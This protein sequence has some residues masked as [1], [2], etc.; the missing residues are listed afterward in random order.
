MDGPNEDIYGL[1]ICWAVNFAHQTAMG[2]YP[3]VYADPY[4]LLAKGKLIRRH[5]QR[6]EH[7]LKSRC[8]AL[9]WQI[10]VSSQGTH[11]TGPVY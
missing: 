9:K 4:M 6:I 8:S 11:H 1:D 2:I 5:L 7:L 3:T 10:L